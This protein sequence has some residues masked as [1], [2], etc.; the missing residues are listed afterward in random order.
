[1]LT[2]V[3]HEFLRQ[4]EGDEKDGAPPAPSPTGQHEVPAVMAL[5]PFRS[6]REASPDGLKLR[7][8]NQLGN[9]MRLKL[10]LAL[11]SHAGAVQ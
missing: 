3:A 6:R 2:A 10:V 11:A 7:M 9:G 5:Q 8:T 1:M 4:T